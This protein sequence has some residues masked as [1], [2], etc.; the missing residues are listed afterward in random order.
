MKAKSVAKV[1]L[2]FNYVLVKMD[3]TLG[4]GSTTKKW[5]ENENGA[6]P[7]FKP[8]VLS[9]IKTIR[10]KKKHADKESIFDHILPNL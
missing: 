2:S 8:V 6:I 9:T 4:T 1:S 10:N 5:N 7:L 3:S